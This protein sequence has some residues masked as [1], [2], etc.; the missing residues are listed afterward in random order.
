MQQNIS[1]RGITRLTD[2]FG[3]ADPLCA[4]LTVL[5]HDLG[6]CA[7][8]AEESRAIHALNIVKVSAMIH[9]RP[10]LLAHNHD[11]GNPYAI[12]AIEYRFDPEG[13]DGSKARDKALEIAGH[14][15]L[16]ANMRGAGLAFIEWSLI[17]EGIVNALIGTRIRESDDR[18]SLALRMKIITADTR[19][20]F[21][22]AFTDGALLAMLHALD[23]FAQPLGAR[24]WT[25]ADLHHLYPAARQISLAM[26]ERLRADREAG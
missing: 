6:E 25:D 7:D 10:M 12:V 14:R 5:P 26:A 17:H 9:D 19:D 18:E 24:G 16:E 11:D 20:D 15:L 21:M 3:L 13:D 22:E 8:L 4:H 23:R 1:P 2:T